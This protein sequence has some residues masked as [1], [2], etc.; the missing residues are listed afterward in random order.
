MTD[1]L[2]LSALDWWAEAGVDTIV[3]DLPYDWLAATSPVAP[4]PATPASAAAVAAAL[5]ATL[6][7]FRRWLIADAPIPGPANNRID[8]IG[9]PASGTM[10]IVDMPEA[11]DRTSG[12]LLSGDAG[13]LFDRMLAA[14]KLERAAIY[15]APFSPARS[16]TGRLSESDCAALAPLMR[17][18]IALAA[19]KRVL[20][21]GDAPTKALLGKPLAQARGETRSL[22]IA[23]FHIPTIASFHPRFVLERPDYRKPAWADLQMFMAL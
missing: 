12:T 5:P 17:Q 2:A 23:G 15:M 21:M 7:E 1:G 6:T 8:A 4:E 3:G 19:P 13:A 16:A 14:M 10:V 20:L 22:E 18:H 9:N 11:A